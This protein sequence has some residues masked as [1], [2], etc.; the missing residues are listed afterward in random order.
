VGTDAVDPLQFV[1]ESID[2][3]PPL[4]I[5][6]AHFNDPDDPDCRVHVRRKPNHVFPSLNASI[7][8]AEEDIVV[9]TECLSGLIVR[10]S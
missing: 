7:D 5:I 10:I 3:A 9:Q 8:K 4:M 1:T 2:P 6:R